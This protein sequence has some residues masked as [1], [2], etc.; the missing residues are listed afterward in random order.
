MTKPKQPRIFNSFL[1]GVLPLLI[2]VLVTNIIDDDTL[3][4]AVIKFMSLIPEKHIEETEV[5]L[6]TR[7]SK[8]SKEERHKKDD[9]SVNRR[10]GAND[11]ID[12]FNRNKNKGQDYPRTQNK[13]VHSDV[14]ATRD[15]KAHTID[16]NIDKLR[17]KY[18][19]DTDNIYNALRLAEALRHRD[20][21]IH[22]GGSLQKEA[23]NTYTTAIKLIKKQRDSVISS[24]GDIRLSKIGRL[25]HSVEEMFLSN[26]DKSIQ[27]LLVSTL[28]NLG[29]Q[30]FMANMFEK[31]VEAYNEALELEEEYLDA[32]NSRGSA[33]FILGKY[34][35]AGNDY[36][37]VLS[38]DQ[39]N[40]FTDVFTG[41]TK[42]FIAKKGVVQKGW[43]EMVTILREK[44]PNQE[45]V[46]ATLRGDSPDSV[47]NRQILSN[48]LVSF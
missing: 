25:E 13:K 34:E 16:E 22:D 12:N 8:K 27:I 10:D 2:L 30:Y 33:L 3:T 6:N 38:I 46:M 45:K 41:L 43:D 23:I 36:V 32:I 44:I 26:E 35:E 4:P 40:L 9:P 1:I 28:T 42:V 29:K 47:Q 31:A 18:E 24:G 17:I 21:I 37:K 39:G 19:N 48:K 11:H 15:G 7:K 14:T 5:V 20:L